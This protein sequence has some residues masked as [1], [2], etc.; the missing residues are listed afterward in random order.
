M[1][2]LTLCTF[3]LIDMGANTIKHPSCLKQAHCPC[4]LY[5]SPLSQEHQSTQI[6]LA[7]DVRAGN[8]VYICAHDILVR[9][10]TPSQLMYHACAQTHCVC[11]DQ[12]RLRTR[13]SRALAPSVSA[14]AVSHKVHKHTDPSRAQWKKSQFPL[15]RSSVFSNVHCVLCDH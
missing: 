13:A 11:A 2:I 7:Q 4:I 14:H 1:R 10:C 3:D 12:A 6:Y 8:V 9:A 5:V 15:M